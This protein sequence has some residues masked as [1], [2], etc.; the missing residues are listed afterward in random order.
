M[1]SI[2]TFLLA[3]FA[4]GCVGVSVAKPPDHAPAHG[5]RAKQY[6]GYTGAVWNHDYSV[7]SGR[8]NREEIGAVLGGVAGGVVGREVADRD[9]RVVGTIVGAALGALIGAKVGRELDERD[10]ACIGDALEVGVDGRSVTWSNAVTGVR[11][12]LVPK[13]GKKK[14]KNAACREF[15]FVAHVSGQRIVSSRTACQA[16]PGVWRLA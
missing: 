16:S 1:R 5:W 12:E 8:C 7:T 11:Y 9:D 4:M 13:V 2:R 3:A 6:V 10:R 15:T 14:K